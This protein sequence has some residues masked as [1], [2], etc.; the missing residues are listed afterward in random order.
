MTETLAGGHPADY[1]DLAQRVRSHP[2]VDGP[3]A[4]WCDRG[5]NVSLRTRSRGPRWP[6]R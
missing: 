6:S 5:S 3:T 1:R 2:F 4:S